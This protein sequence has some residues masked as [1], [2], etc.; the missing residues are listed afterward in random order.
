MNKSLIPYTKNPVYDK[1]WFDRNWIQ[2]GDVVLITIDGDTKVKGVVTCL[3]MAGS[4]RLYD[5]RR[6]DNYE[7]LYTVQ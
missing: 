5:V 7:M 1:E 3:T 6:I 4:T 2:A